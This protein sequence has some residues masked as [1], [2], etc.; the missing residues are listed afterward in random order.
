MARC[1]C[2]LLAVMCTAVVLCQGATPT[3]PDSYQANEESNI[4]IAQG[5]TYVNGMPCCS[6]EA[7]CKVQTEYQVGVGYRDGKHNRT[8]FDG[9]GQS[10]VTDY[11]INKEMLIDPSNMT[12][13]E[14][15]PTEFEWD[16]S[17]FWPTPDQ[18]E[19]V[20]DL[21]KTTIAGKVVN[22]YRWFEKIL[23][24]IKMQQTDFFC[25]I[26]TSG[27]AIPVHEADII[28]P[29]GQP[30]ANQNTTWSSFTAGD[31]DPNL[32]NVNGIKD[33]P[34]S[35]NCGNSFFQLRRLRDRNY[36]GFLYYLQH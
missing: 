2:V 26:P 18:H 1:A 33:C 19:P 21:G 3:F 11:V 15:C 6:M 27:D 30:L 16:S 29:F 36:A 13:M 4:V 9:G 12:C 32:F 17:P 20:Q 24:I 22:H 35:P 5:A 14:Y 34:M 8:R 28:E 31:P 25:T 7:E 23:R 10:I